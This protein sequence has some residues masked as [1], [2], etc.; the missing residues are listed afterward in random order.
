MRADGLVL[1]EWHVDDVSAM[2]TLF[3]TAEMDRWTPLAHPFDA[4]VAADYVR[5]AHDARSGGTLQL[6]ITRDGGAPLGEV[7]L[8]PSPTPGVCE[9][10]YAVGA[11]HRGQALAAHAITALLPVAKATGY[12]RATLTIALDNL[13]S[14]G[15]ARAAGFRRD[16]TPVTR[17][18]RKGYILDMGIW[19]RAT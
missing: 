19:A 5:Q 6:A 7:I 9:F 10:A 14:Q 18:Q 15:V 2:V 1:R 4:Q 11:A 12:R 3:D 8:F 16:S 13:A 17:R